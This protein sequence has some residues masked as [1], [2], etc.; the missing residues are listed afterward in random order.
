MEL[1]HS[2]VLFFACL[3]PFP[4]EKASSDW[5]WEVLISSGREG[6]YS[7]YSLDI[8]RGL[9]SFPGSK[10]I[11]IPRH[12]K[13]VYSPIKTARPKWSIE[14]NRAIDA[15][16][17]CFKLSVDSQSMKFDAFNFRLEKN[18]KTRLNISLQNLVKFSFS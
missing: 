1:F 6:R 9:A 13:I 4:L 8:S 14:A 15:D 2:P 7:L 10:F 12:S 3:V 5:V 17:R 11:Q 18:A 16:L